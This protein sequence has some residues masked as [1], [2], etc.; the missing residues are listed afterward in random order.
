MSEAG[1]E[2]SA[3]LLLA[4]GE[5]ASAAVFPYL[6]P[7]EVS[8][9]GA[10]MRALDVLPRER[11]RAVLRDYAREA[12][13]QTGFAADTAR[14]LDQAITRAWPPERAQLMLRRL[15]RAG[16]HALD[17]LALREPADLA[18]MLESQPAAL[19]AVVAAHLPRDLAAAMLDILPAAVRAAALAELARRETPAAE[20]LSELEDWLARITPPPKPEAEGE[21][22]AANLLGRMSQGAATAALTQL[23]HAD[24]GLAARLRARTIE[25]DDL[26][27]TSVDGR[28]H[29]LRQVGA[30][31]LLLALKGS[32]GRVL[33]AL[34]AVMSPAAALRMRDDLDTLGAVPVAEIQTAQQEAVAVLR[35]LAAEG[36]LQFD[37]TLSA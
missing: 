13:E 33:T 18:G 7:L 9:L 16:T 36:A 29:F 22:V 1:I 32:D 14:F 5:D 28:R 35:R 30:R 34:S 19:V 20:S 24:A 8:R 27:R 2:K 25:F 12:A 6:S 21:A 31:T 4:L 15:G 11:V 3:A 26:L 37:E 10:A 17:A 23:D